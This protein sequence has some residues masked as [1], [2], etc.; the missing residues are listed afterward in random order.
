[1]LKESQNFGTIEQPNEVV[2]TE[3]VE[4]DDSW[5]IFGYGTPG[6]SNASFFGNVWSD[7][8]FNDE[9]FENFPRYMELNIWDKS[10]YGWDQDKTLVLLDC[11][12]LNERLHSSAMYVHI[13]EKHIEDYL[14]NNLNS[15]VL[16]NLTLDYI[17][18][19][20]IAGGSLLLQITNCV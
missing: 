17:S 9:L 12:V 15:L 7:Q 10:I 8:S 1:M 16:S 19:G 13:Y 4:N 6:L 11:S 18:L 2:L 5:E 3:I 14:S 20:K